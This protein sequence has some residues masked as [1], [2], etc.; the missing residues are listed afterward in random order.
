[1]TRMDEAYYEPISHIVDERDAGQPLG[2]VLRRRL[3]C[4]RKLLSRLKLTE[5]GITVNG[6]RRYTNERVAVGDRIEI[7]MPKERSEDILP[8][9]MEL[10]VLFEDA[11]LMAV[12]KPA[13]L[14]VHPT[15]GHYVNT[16][17]NGVVHHWLERGETVRFRPVHR[18][19]QH[20]SGVLLIAKTPYAH[21]QLS[22]QIQR[23]RVEKV[24]LA[25]VHG[26]TP[27]RGTIDAPID[28]NPEQ[29][30]IR[31]VRPD[32]YP[33]VT[34]YEAVRR[35]RG[36]TLLRVMLETGRT[37][38]I[39]V[40]MKHIGHPLVGDPMYGQP[41]ADRA[42]GA[43]MDRQALHA[44]R[45]G[46]RHPVSGEPMLLEAEMPPDMARCIEVLSAREETKEE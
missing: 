29:P 25:L 14:I 33:S 35:L 12:N 9:P 42:A 21:Q 7:R 34:H 36:V 26:H 2:T 16:L 41:K 28:R 20:T 4:S 38:Q 18:L 30:H 1:M 37:H 24:Y 19:D 17:A 15:H 31:M 46:F 5:R 11:D 40:H 32:G 44:W 10:D 8:Q 22:E 6:Q 3:K 23:K 43:A 13:G 39:R 27:D 45:L